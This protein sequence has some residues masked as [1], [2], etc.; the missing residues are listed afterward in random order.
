MQQYWQRN[1]ERS[2]S[3]INHGIGT[4]AFFRTIEQEL[5]EDR[6][7]RVHRS[8]IIALDKIESVERSQIIINKERITIAEQYKPKFQA[9]IE[10]KSL[11]AHNPH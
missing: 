5:P 2:E 9:F 10:N 6:F 3:L 4:E 1:F 8:Y 11:S 7:M